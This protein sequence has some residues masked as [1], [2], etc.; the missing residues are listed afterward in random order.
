MN[1]RE[2]LQSLAAI[3]TALAIDPTALASASEPEIE[4]AWVA[5]SEEPRIFYVSEFGT[6][7]SG[8]G[9]EY[10]TTRQTLLDLP[11]PGKGREALIRYL[12]EEPM[13]ERHVEHLFENAEY[14]GEVGDATDWREWLTHGDEDL[15]DTVGSEI[16]QW[17]EDHPAESDWEYA[18]LH[19]LSD[20][21]D[22]MQFFRNEADI[23]DLF[24]IAI[25]EGDHPGSSYFAAELRGDI[26]EA[27]ALAEAQQIPIRFA[28]DGSGC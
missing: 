25:V 28:Y 6:L 7:S 1:R 17:L 10:P 26:D 8:F 20:R 22:A 23:A 9:P 21:G 3:G 12:E 5:L 18:D 14:E 13:A 15:I 11:S 24:N 27:N 2:F 19:G 4:A 16:E